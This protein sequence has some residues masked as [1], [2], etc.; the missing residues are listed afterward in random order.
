MDEVKCNG[1]V[2]CDN[3]LDVEKQVARQ[4]ELLFDTLLDYMLPGNHVLRKTINC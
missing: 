1:N 2:T 4:V 3:C